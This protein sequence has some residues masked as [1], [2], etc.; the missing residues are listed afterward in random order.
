MTTFAL[1]AAVRTV[2]SRVGTWRGYEQYS[3]LVPELTREEWARAIGEARAHLSAQTSELTKP[4]N[5]RP[6]GN[7]IKGYTSKRARG[8][9]QQ[10]SVHV[11]DNDTGILSE[12]VYVVRGDT[13]RSRLSAVN[14]ARRKY[15]D[16]IDANPDEYPE[17]IVGVEYKGTYLL[18]PGA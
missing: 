8:F 2:K 13:L 15:Q 7:D 14:E 3:R 16:S 4:L 12:K 11:R 9:M 1:W 6:V 17:T 10:V 18:T 5:Q